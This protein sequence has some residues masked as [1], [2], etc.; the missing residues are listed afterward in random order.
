MPKGGFWFWLVWDLKGGL[1]DELCC[2]L[3]LADKT[4]GD[5]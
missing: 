1:E 3:L 4:G 2:S 5:Q